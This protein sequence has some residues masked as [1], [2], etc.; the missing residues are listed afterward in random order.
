M[1]V[2]WPLKASTWITLQRSKVVAICIPIAV[3]I[4]HIP[5]P[6]LNNYTVGVKAFYQIVCFIIPLICVLVLNLLITQKIREYNRNRESLTKSEHK[7]LATTKMLWVVSFMYFCCCIFVTFTFC[8]DSGTLLILSTP[9]KSRLV[10]LGVELCMVL[11]ASTNYI[12][13]CC[14]DKGFKYSLKV[15]A[16]RQYDFSDLKNS[17]V[18]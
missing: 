14:F 16:C 8:A 2:M 15:L 3:I 1:V 10:Q 7:K 4:L 11:N 5:I 12:I 17:S 18:T 9:T 13:Y 6:L